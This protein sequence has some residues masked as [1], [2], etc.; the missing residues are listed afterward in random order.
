M[1][2]SVKWKKIETK[3]SKKL[4]KKKNACQMVITAKEKTLR[5]KNEVVILDQKENQV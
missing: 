1:L 3:Q 2:F 4:K 5:R